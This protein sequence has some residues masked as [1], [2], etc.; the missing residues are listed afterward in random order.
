MAT[1]LA[2]IASLPL[3]GFLM[4]FHI[5]TS[6]SPLGFL[7]FLII[8]CPGVH[9]AAMESP[10]PDISFEIFSTFVQSTFSSKISLSTVLMMLFTVTENT[11]LL[12]LHAR[13]QNPQFS[14]EQKRD[15]STW[16]NCLAHAIQ[17]HTHEKRLKTLFKKKEIPIELIG[18]ESREIIS[19]KL[20]SFANMLGLN[21]FGSN[22]QLIR[23]LQPVSDNDIQPILVLCPKSYECM[24]G[25]CKPRCL[26]LQTRQSQI[27]E[28]TLIKGSKIF[29]N[30]SVLTGHCPNCKTAY[31][32]DHEKYGPSQERKKTFLNDAKYLKVGQSTYVDRVF[33]NAVI[34]GIYSFHAS[35]AAYAEFWTN[36]FGKANSVKL[37]RRHVWQTF[38]Q[39]SIRR[40]SHTLEITFETNDS[41][42]IAELTNKAYGLL[43]EN[44]GI[45]LSNG[46]TCS[47]CTQDY[48]ATADYATQNNDPA[49]V[50][51]V[52]DDR[53]VPAL[54]DGNP[55]NINIAN[56][57]LAPAPSAA[58]APVKMVVV[59]GLVMGPS[60]CA[61]D[62][63][64]AD[65]INARGEALCALHCSQFANRCRVVGCRI[66]K[67]QGTQACQQ[68]QQDWTQFKQTRTKSTLA[69]VRRMLNHQNENLPWNQ[70]VE[71][72]IQSHEE[73]PPEAQRK[74]YFSAGRWYCVE[75]IC[76]PCGVVIAWTK[77]DRSESPTKI[78]K[79]L[80][81]TYPDKDTR[82]DYI[83]I[84]KGCLVLRTCLANG[85]WEEWKE[86][87]R[88]IVD[89]FHYANHRVGDY[90]CRKFCNPAPLDGSA[91]NLVI[92]AETENGVKYLK[93]A[94]N[95]QV[96][97]Q[98]I[99]M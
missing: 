89:A 75:T 90:I 64:T 58:K 45:R 37:P 39:E 73:D 11:D 78:L 87:C 8:F 83:C 23:K 20:D 81:D 34:N 54:A 49:A 53:P 98:S 66:P 50:L 3:L 22:G 5:I 84:D 86:T 33:S 88:I 72:D 74:N 24:D 16:M 2:S 85:S 27:P 76:A 57:P 6:L 43:G 7:L 79:F 36:S 46:H 41:L 52:D 69:G 32:V 92:E 28:V 96:N 65:L 55:D 47:E 31:F 15:S 18:I 82:P 40:I 95:T 56:Q 67:L 60:H 62:N 4:I 48:K 63:C 97:E 80:K 14:F 51:G 13:Q 91:P 59:D 71:H 19:I 1:V 35:T 99:Y 21:P 93:R 25:K 12:N 30:V 68:H 70:R 94:F 44:G 10:F 38:I 26:L 77:F 61:A 9:A 42:T 17:K 29:K